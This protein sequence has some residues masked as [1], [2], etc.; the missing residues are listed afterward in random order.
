M[1]MPG[2]AAIKFWILPI[3]TPIL[4]MP[5]RLTKSPM[6]I[7]AALILLVTL[8]LFVN[9]TFALPTSPPPTSAPAIPLATPTPPA[10]QQNRHILPRQSPPRN[11]NPTLCTFDG[12]QD[13]YGL[14]IRI[15]YYIQ[16]VATVFGAYFTPKV[17]SSA[18]EANALFNIGMLAGLVYSTIARNDMHLLEPI[19]VLGFSIGG[20][21]VGLLD[22]KNVHHPKDLKSLRRRLVHLAATGALYLPLLTYWVWF[23][24]HGMDTLRTEGDACIP[25]TFLLAKIDARATWFRTF[26]KVTTVISIVVICALAGFLAVTYRAKSH[27]LPE[28]PAPRLSRTTTALALRARP[29]KLQ[30]GIV[31]FACLICALSVEL[32]ILWN[33]IGGVNGLG[34]TGQLIPMAIGLL[35]SIRVV[36]G[37][38]GLKFRTRKQRRKEFAKERMFGRRQQEMQRR[39]LEDD[40]DGDTDRNTDADGMTMTISRTTSKAATVRTFVTADEE[41]EVTEPEQKRRKLKRKRTEEKGEKAVGFEI[42]E[43]ETVA[44]RSASRATSVR[45]RREGDAGEEMEQSSDSQ[46]DSPATITPTTESPTRPTTRS[47]QGTGVLRKDPSTKDQSA[48]DQSAKEQIGKEHSGKDQ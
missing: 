46:T 40:G 10:Q 6:R 23:S 22:P 25:Y 7:N 24:F 44:S 38:V 4:K 29:T 15:G 14:G 26:M 17:V 2:C 37:I 30:F 34:A 21:I 39:D 16:W 36:V 27:I 33:N 28:N 47:R 42:R 5:M 11:A 1:S 31:I 48:K 3:M 43:I 41:G 45:T 12:D 20:A 32:P 19:I 35:T 13:M 18:F 9:L 8:L